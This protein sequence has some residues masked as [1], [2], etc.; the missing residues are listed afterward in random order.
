M[1]ILRQ[2][3]GIVLLLALVGCTPLAAMEEGMRETARQSQLND[4]P[5]PIR[6]TYRWKF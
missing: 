1:M 3:L 2:L 6:Y 5:I 4:L